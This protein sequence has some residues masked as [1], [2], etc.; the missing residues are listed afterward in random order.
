MTGRR[1]APASARPDVD[2]Q[3]VIG[4]GLSAAAVRAQ[5]P[6]FLPRLAEGASRRGWSFGQPFFIRRCRVG[7][8]ND[9]GDRLGRPWSC[10]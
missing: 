6:E 4:D 5:V 1:D 10:S 7:A 8:I 3:V 9:V 2:L